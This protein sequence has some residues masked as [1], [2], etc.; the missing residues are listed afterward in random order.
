MALVWLVQPLGGLEQLL[1]GM[2][3]PC[4]PRKLRADHAFLVD[5]KRRRDWNTSLTSA[6]VFVENAVC[7]DQFAVWIRQQW[8]RNLL[9]PRK[10]L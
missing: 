3:D 6:S 4:R 1:G 8:I 10:L 7:G 2:P 5:H 9:S